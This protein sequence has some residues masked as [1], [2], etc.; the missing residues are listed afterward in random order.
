MNSKSKLIIIFFLIVFSVTLFGQQSKG[1]IK[2]KVIDIET[3]Q[4]LIGVNV[5]ISSINTGSATDENGIYEI[6]N[7]NVGSYTVVFSY[8]G[9]ERHSQTDVIVRSERITFVNI[10]MKPTSINMKDVEVKSGYFTTSETQQ[11]SAVSFSFEEIRRAPGAGGDV[12]RIIFGLPSLAKINDTKNSLI[13]RGGSP[14]ENG[15]YIDNIEIPNINHF[16][17]QG[18]SEGPIGIINVD[19][20]D[21]VNFYSG[22]FSSVYGDKLSSIMELNF[23]EG[24]RSEIDIQTDLSLQGFGG[25]IEG[26]INNGNGSF[27]FSARRSYLDLILDFMGEKVGLPV[28]SDIQGKV[29]YD[30]SNNHKISLINVFSYDRQLMNQEDAK[31]NKNNVYNDYKYY[32][33]TTGINWLYLWGKKGYSNSSFSHTYMKTDALFFQ[34]KDA[35]LL[36]D[37]NSVEQEYKFRNNNNLFINPS[38]KFE[39]GIDGRIVINDY[40]QFYNEYQDLLGNKTD[41]LLVNKNIETYKTGAFVNTTWEPVTNL[42]LNPGLRFDY[43]R[44]NKTTNLSPRISITY[45]FNEAT[46]LTGTFGVYYQ[47][48]PWVLAAQNEEFKKLKNPKSHHYIIGLCHLLTEST[49]LTIEVYNK[50]YFYF[51]MNQS[52]PSL[53]VFDQAVIESLFLTHANLESKGEANSKGIELTIQK[54]L[55]KDFY[56]LISASYSKAKYKGLDNRWYDRVYDNQFTFALEGGYK[57]NESWEFS[58]RWLYAGGAPFTPFDETV[59]KEVNKGVF[60]ESKINGERLPDFHSL[61]IRADKRFHFSKSTL[62]VYLSVWNAYARKN[63][64]AYTWNEIDNKRDEEKMWGLLPVFGIEYEF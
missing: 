26:P 34:T 56:G 54:K 44:Y 32:T 16:P 27:V 7:L 64:A 39:F 43:Y 37:N 8:I 15:F 49:R 36:L 47:N 5:F 48:I 18:S 38:L 24:N 46:S 52:Q 1:T 57:P 12:S 42:I 53:F 10:E 23:R 59:S 4:P 11:I 33:N 20:I 51:P 40:N 62:I 14:V 63:I 30:L 31:E 22:G 61:N 58:A 17:V 35:K 60:N 19:L 3:K 45:K 9:Y 6:S 50:D 2:G 41:A 13:V 29:I 25:V 28:Y 55:A 21:N